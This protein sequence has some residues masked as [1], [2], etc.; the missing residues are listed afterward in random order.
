MADK[1]IQLGLEL[2]ASK[3]EIVCNIQRTV[4]MFSIY[5]GFKTVH[6]SDL[7]SL[8]SPV[9]SSPTVD[10]VLESKCEDLVRA[11]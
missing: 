2:N 1:S 9:H 3:C 7:T 11:V 5:G 10:A 4:E 8:G 6:L